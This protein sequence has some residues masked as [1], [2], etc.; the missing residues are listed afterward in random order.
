[1]CKHKGSNCRKIYLLTVQETPFTLVV[2][3]LGSMD[4]IKDQ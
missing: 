4:L 1:M 3:N 2:L